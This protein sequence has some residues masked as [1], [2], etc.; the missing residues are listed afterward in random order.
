MVVEFVCV[1][2]LGFLACDSLHATLQR[3][4]IRGN[5][6]LVFMA[7]SEYDALKRRNEP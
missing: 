2:L 4:R 5:G 6:P 1:F 7:L 3:R